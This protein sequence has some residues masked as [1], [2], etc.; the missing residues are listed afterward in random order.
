M[1]NT[2]GHIAEAT[3]SN[4]FW[5]ESGTV[6]TPPLDCGALPGVTRAFVEKLCGNLAIPVIEENVFPEALDKVE[7]AFLTS[8]GIGIR[9]VASVAG[10]A[11]APSKIT[12]KLR[13][14]FQKH[15]EGSVT[16]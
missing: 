12:Q 7:G 5:I 1:R 2:D 10:F 4:F 3:S 16:I 11:F 6:C 13:I 14:E 9:D 8:S 15:A